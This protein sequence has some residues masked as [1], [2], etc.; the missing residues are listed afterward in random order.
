MSGIDTSSIRFGVATQSAAGTLETNPTYLFGVESGDIPASPAFD[1]SPLTSGSATK[2]GREL[3]RVEWPFDFTTRAYEGSIGLLL[4][5][6]LGE[7]ATTGT[8]APYSHVFNHARPLPA[9]ISVFKE[10]S[11]GGD[12]HAVRDG[13]ISSLRL[14]WEENAPLVVAVDG[15]GTVYSS[16]ASIS[17][18][19]DE[20]NASTYFRPVGG[21]F[22]MDLDGTSVA[23]RCMKGGFVELTNAISADFCSGTLEA[24]SISDNT[25]DATCGLTIKPADLTEWE[26]IVAAIQAG[27][28]LYGSIDLTFKSDTNTLKI[29]AQRIGFMPYAIPAASGGTEAEVELGGVCYTPSG[30]DGPVRITLTNSV[31]SY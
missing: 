24:T 31:A 27:T 28:D 11:D 23:A 7:C 17:A 18:T 22:K 20:T 9:G 4:K 25:H 6:A 10:Y 30:W 13:K 1:D 2:G 5:H 3:R 26:A 15:V 12:I 21:T 16:P 19:T 29:E 14:S 8:A